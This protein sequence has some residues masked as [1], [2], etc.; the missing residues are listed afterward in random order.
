MPYRL[1]GGFKFYERKEIKDLLAYLRLYVNPKE[2]VSITRVQKIGKRRYQ[3][4][5]DWRESYQQGDTVDAS[6]VTIL[7]EILSVTN[8]QELYDPHDPED[9]QKLENI[10]E[11]LS[12]AS[13]FTSIETFLENIALVQDDNYGPDG[14]LIP[15]KDRDEVTLMSLH[16]AKG[17]EFAVVFLVGME[18]NILPHSRS[19]FDADQLAEERRLC[20][21]GITRA[22]EK[23]YFTHCRRRWSY[24]GYTTCCRSRFLDDLDPSLLE[25]N[26]VEDYS[27]S[28]DGDV[29][30]R[31]RVPRSRQTF[32]DDSRTIDLDDSQL[33]DFLL[34]DMDAADFLRS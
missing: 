26:R 34:G 24:T 1:V 5:L 29:L 12:H 30:R 19:I 33:D 15:E 10:K 9:V 3:K 17:L 21:V 4:Y 14:Q 6:P 28:S 23:L 31:R 13:Q 2:S 8:Y 20:Y 16:A 27:Q 25:I 32:I 18:E 7:Q 22:K 11:L